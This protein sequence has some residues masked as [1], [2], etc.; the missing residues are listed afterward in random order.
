MADG[1]TPTFRGYGTQVDPADPIVGLS[2][3]SARMAVTASGRL[4]DTKLLTQ[5]QMIEGG[6]WLGKGQP[7]DAK[8]PKAQKKGR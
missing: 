5:E 4:I 7:S 2:A 6:I 3:L 1:T 8:A